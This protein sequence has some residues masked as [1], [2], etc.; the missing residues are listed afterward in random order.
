MPS[1]ADCTRFL[2]LACLV[3]ALSLGCSSKSAPEDNLRELAAE[4]APTFDRFDAWARRAALGSDA[5]ASDS[6]LREAAFAPLREEED[7]LGAWIIEGPPSPS[8]VAMHDAP[9]PSGLVWRRRVLAASPHLEVARASLAPRA[10][11]TPVDVVLLSRTVAGEN[12]KATIQVIVAFSALE[13][14]APSAH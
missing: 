14:S 2:G 4:H 5:F 9:L 6:A 8:T 10:R 12:E 1:A 3:F 7:V 11:A 13:P